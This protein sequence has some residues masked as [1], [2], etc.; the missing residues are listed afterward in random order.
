M[1]CWFPRFVQYG[2]NGG[3]VRRLSAH[4]ILS[5]TGRRGNSMK[6][7]KVET[8][9]VNVT[10]DEPLANMPENANAIR[11]VVTLRLHTDDGI[12]G[13]GITFYGAAM[14]GALR[15]AVDEL[16]ALTIGEDPLRIEAI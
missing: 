7:A 5:T 15:K 4:A 6:I 1:A 3:W 11:P 2:R 8:G 16:A 13:I 10:E 14:T 9:I 12:E